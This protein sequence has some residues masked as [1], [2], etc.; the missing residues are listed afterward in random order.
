VFWSGPGNFVL[1][2]NTTIDSNTA[3]RF[4]S[5]AAK[6]WEIGTTI[7]RWED[8]RQSRNLQRYLVVLSRKNRTGSRDSIEKYFVR[9][10]RK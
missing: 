4:M 7:L 6:I 2:W 9:G 8:A 5:L 3:E 10:V 1:Q